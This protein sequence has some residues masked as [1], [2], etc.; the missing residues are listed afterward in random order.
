MEIL[1]FSMMWCGVLAIAHAAE[2]TP[3]LIGHFNNQRLSRGED[4]HILSGY[5][6]DL[7]RIGERTFGDAN[8]GVG[9]TEAASGRLYDI[10]F[11]PATKRL[12]FS[13]KFTAG[14]EFGKGIPAAGRPFRVVMKF[15]GV[16]GPKALSGIVETRDGY[17]NDS[18][19]KVTRVKIGR[20]P[21]THV[22]VSYDHWAKISAPPAVW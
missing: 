4:V 9:S 5:Y 11:N 6:V 19:S 21:D 16:V 22:P 2:P 15:K 17:G 20:T 3:V 13:A 12:S 7:Y 1:Y 18:V 8:I 14:W 10:D